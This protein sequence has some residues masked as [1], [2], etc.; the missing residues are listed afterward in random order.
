MKQHV[1]FL[2]L[3]AV[4]LTTFGGHAVPPARESQFGNPEEPALRVVKW[5]WL[6]LRK[7]VVRTHEGLEEG[8]HRHPPAALCKGARGAAHGG[9]ILIDH[10][11]RGLIHAPLPPREPLRKR[12]TYEERALA[13]IEAMAGAE[14]A[15]VEDAPVAQPD[16]ETPPAAVDKAEEDAPR[17]LPLKAVETDVERAQRRYIPDRAAYRNRVRAG[18]GN[19]LR[20]AR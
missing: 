2:V 10:S 12:V 19:L 18:G 3:G 8:A 6:G 17:A 9:G 4:V 15:A 14:D 16:V 20:L 13:F 7:L 5:P 1:L 11:A